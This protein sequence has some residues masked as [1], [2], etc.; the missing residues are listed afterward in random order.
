MKNTLLLS[1]ILLTS[2]IQLKAQDIIVTNKND[3]IICKVL[4]ESNELFAYKYWNDSKF[5]NRV[6]EKNNTKSYIKDFYRQNIDNQYILSILHTHYII[7]QNNDTIYCDLVKET[8]DTYIYSEKINHHDIIQ[9]INRINTKKLKN[10][11]GKRNGAIGIYEI[12]LNGGF[13]QRNIII[14][15]NM[16]PS[17]EE[18]FKSVKN[19]YFLG[20]TSHYYLG[21][22]FALGLKYNFF[23]SYGSGYYY[24]YFDNG[25]NINVRTKFDIR[26]NY[27]AV[28]GLISLYNKNRK[29]KF[30]V[31]ANFGPMTYK[32]IAD[33]NYFI[34]IFKGKTIGFGFGSNLSYF[35]SKGIGVNIHGS[36][37]IG[38]IGKLKSENDFN[39]KTIKLDNEEKININQLNLG[40]GIVIQF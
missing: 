14:A 15:E 29:L 17:Q 31:T 2:I 13:A 3:T 7:T 1:L 4:G 16:P 28:E 23:K 6:I 40:A 10:L 12:I 32:E 37:S 18:L 34:T 24:F 36:Y 9:E 22:N 20:L 8:T 30:D 11:K 19:G 21:G 33:I 39:S 26:I 38:K 27:Y 25:D 5:E 35:F